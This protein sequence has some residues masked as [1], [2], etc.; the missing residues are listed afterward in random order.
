MGVIIP[1]TRREHIFHQRNKA[2]S[3]FFWI[4]SIIG[5]TSYFGA[6]FRTFLVISICSTVPSII[7]SIFIKKTKWY[8]PTAYII[9]TF[10]YLF[11]TCLMLNDPIFFYYLYIFYPISLTSVYQN[12]KLSIYSYVLATIVTV[13]VYQLA[14]ETMFHTTG[15]RELLDTMVVISFGCVVGILQ[16]ISNEKLQR[17][18]EQNENNVTEEKDKTL[19]ILSK[20]GVSVDVLYKFNEKFRNNVRSTINTSQETS[21]QFIQIFKD[22]NKQ[23]LE[24]QS[25][26]KTIENNHQFADQTND[27]VKN[28]KNSSETITESVMNSDQKFEELKNNM[29]SMG[30]IIEETVISMDRLV[31]QNKKIENIIHAIEEIS[32]QTNLLALNAGIEAERAG[33]H[34]KGFSVVASEVKKLSQLTREAVKEIIQ[35]I[36]EVNQRTQEA[37]IKATSGKTTFVKSN[38][39]LD[40]TEVYFKKIKTESELIKKEVKQVTEKMFLLQQ[41]TKETLDQTMIVS[42]LSDSNVETTRQIDHS[43]SQQNKEVRDLVENFK[44]LEKETSALISLLDKK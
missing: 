6:P 34:G 7:I 23:N 32:S 20:V 4:T 12:K 11:V 28:V 41:A 44:E 16:S 22:S 19:E 2:I 36:Q 26:K 5:Y 14:K 29:V 13:T 15:Y 25:I 43:L 40:E 21:N 9:V 27:L 37:T 30:G 3:M 33:E 35:I 18:I 1:M 10:L 17:E 31:Q 38:H 42:S 24:I 8:E 39:S